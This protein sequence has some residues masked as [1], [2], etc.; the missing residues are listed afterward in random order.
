M[1]NKHVKHS[2]PGRNPKRTEEQHGA[3]KINN[4][5]WLKHDEREM[6]NE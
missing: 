1:T 6:V 2:A 4:M 3:N 5:T